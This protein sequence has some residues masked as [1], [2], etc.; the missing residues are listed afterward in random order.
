MSKRVASI[1]TVGFA[2]MVIIFS[3]CGMWARADDD[4]PPP[5]EPSLAESGDWAADFNDA[6]IACYNGSMSACDSIYLNN[7]V[8]FDTFLHNYGRSCGGRVDLG[9]FTPRRVWPPTHPLYRDLPR[10]RMSGLNAYPVDVRYAESNG[11]S[12]NASPLLSLTPCRLQELCFVGNEEDVRSRSHG[13]YLCS[14]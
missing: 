12:A 8:L 14:L 1:L 7:R 10:A 4:L 6:Q 9:A 13:G 5:I 11:L 3:G 2:T